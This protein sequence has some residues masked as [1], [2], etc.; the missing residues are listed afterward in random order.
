MVSIAVNT[1]IFT[2]L[3]IYGVVEI[4]EPM[5]VS[6]FHNLFLDFIEENGCYFGGSIELSEDVNK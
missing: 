1:D 4:P 2:I 3:D 6:D 5:T